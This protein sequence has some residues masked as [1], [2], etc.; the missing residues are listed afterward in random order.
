VRRLLNVLLPLA[1]LAPGRLPGE[2]AGWTRRTPEG[3]PG[4]LIL[5]DPRR[6]DRIFSV[7]QPW[8]EPPRALCTLDGGRTWRV[9]YPG[10]ITVNGIG[11]DAVAPSRLYAGGGGGVVRSD[12]DGL[13]WRAA[14]GDIGFSTIGKI[15]VH[16]SRGGFVYAEASSILVGYPLELWHT[17]DGGDHWDR[18]LQ[19][20]DVLAI[21]SSEPDVVYASGGGRV[22]KST[23]GLETYVET[24]S[25]APS[26][27]YGPSLT[28]A[29]SDSSVVY[30]SAVSEG[31]FYRTTNGGATWSPTTPPPLGVGPLAIDRLDPRRILVG[32]VGGVSRSLDGGATW[33]I[34]TGLG[35]ER[36]WD[37]AFDPAEADGIL[38]S[39][40]SGLF[41]RS[42]AASGCI[43]GMEA[44]CL[45]G[46]FR[47]EI[48]RRDASGPAPGRAT[49]LTTDTGAFWFFTENNLEVVVK[50]VDGAAVN[51]RFWVFVGGLTDVEYDLQI[52]D[53]VTG[54]LWRHH[55]DAGT[56]R[57]VADTD[58][59]PS[60]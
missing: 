58:A 6:P 60:D 54:S 30:S 53:S 12:D 32:G 20:F 15:W 22:F 19:A 5:T 28:V 1:L 44:L 50:V 10:L 2:D 31:V 33:T 16:P 21:S 3:F 47:V 27:T 14:R 39:T 56:L 42:S 23:D 26:A 46:R 36:V 29:P 8:P 11:I 18:R 4:G 57:S 13:S 49:G 35:R 43:A 37:V 17:A 7:W 51:H 55:N 40:D 59:F 45:G 41:R 25:P 34:V 38:A 9:S 52:T 48:V 24:S